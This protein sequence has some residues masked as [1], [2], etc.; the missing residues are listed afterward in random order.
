MHKTVSRKQSIIKNDL[1]KLKALLATTAYDVGGEARN[2]ISESFENVKDK[3]TDLQESISD[4][5]SE[6]PFKALGIAMLS[7]LLLGLTM[8][9]KKK[10]Y[11]TR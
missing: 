11:H 5:V 6:K 1:E 8:R 10:H 9:R 2:A 4:Y 7:G 3:S